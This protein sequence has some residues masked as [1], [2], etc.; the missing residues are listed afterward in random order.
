MAAVAEETPVVVHAILAITWVQAAR[1]FHDYFEEVLRQG[2]RN[3][4][5]ILFD[6]A[7]V[8]RCVEAG[9]GGTVE[10]LVGGK[11]DTRHGS[12]VPLLGTVRMLSDGKFVE[13]QIR[14]GGWGAMDQG[15][16][17]VVE[18]AEE[19]TVV[20][21]SKRMAPMSLEQILV[22]HP[23]RTETHSNRQGCGGAKGGVCACSGADPSGGFGGR[24][25]R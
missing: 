1:G 18:T 25:Q 6:P 9:P 12:P 3:S 24:D 10:F 23:P 17:A 16:T 21:T 13:T 8:E 15:I 4:L 14:H 22:G 11:T 5:V 19:H 2:A 7:A 20:L